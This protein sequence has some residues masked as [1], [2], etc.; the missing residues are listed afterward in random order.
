[1]QLEHVKLTLVTGWMSVVCA[2]GLVGGLTSLRSWAVLVGV[3]LLPSVVMMRHW[4][5]PGRTLSQSIR[6][7]RQ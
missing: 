3:S 4:N 2:A 6:E 7:A 5:H 1:M